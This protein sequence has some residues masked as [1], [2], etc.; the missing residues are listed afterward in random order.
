MFFLFL[1][2][3]WCLQ[4]GFPVWSI[5]IFSFGLGFQ[6]D[7]IEIL[8]LEMPFPR[9]K[10][11]DFLFQPWSLG[12]LSRNPDTRNAFSRFEVSRFADL[13]VVRR[14][15]I[16]KSWY[17][18][19]DFQGW[20]ITICLSGGGWQ[21]DY[22]K[23]LIHERWFPGLEYHEIGDGSKVPKMASWYRTLR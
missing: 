18:K 2:I 20:S 16:W 15:I 19:G 13:V 8:I 6:E 10:H 1:G 4:A 5:T 9:L 23:I 22:L 11:H 14:K 7:F 17:M 12:R 21:K 3:V